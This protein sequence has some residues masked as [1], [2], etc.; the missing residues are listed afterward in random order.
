MF[1]NKVYFKGDECMLKETADIIPVFFACD[2]KYVPYV[3][4]AIT[5]ICENTFHP[6]SIC[7]IDGGITDHS[8]KMLTGLAAKREKVSLRI[9]SVDMRI[10]EGMKVNQLSL[11][12]Y[13]RF[14]IPW[15]VPELEKAIYLDSD[16][17]VLGD[18]SDLYRQNLHGKLLAA[19]PD[20]GREPREKLT[21]VNPNY[22]SFGEEHIYFNAGVLV[23]DCKKWREQ[24]VLKELLKI[25]EKYR[26]DMI[27]MDQ[28]VLNKY[29][30]CNYTTLSIE[31]NFMPHMKELC[32]S[33]KIEN[34]TPKMV[35]EAENHCRIIHFAGPVKPWES[36][37]CFNNGE[38]EKFW[39]YT[40]KTPF[41]PGLAA[42]FVEKNIISHINRCV[43]DIR[44]SL[45]EQTAK[46]SGKKK[47]RFLGFLPF[48]SIKYQSNSS[49]K[50]KKLVKV[51]GIPLYSKVQNSGSVCYKLLG[52]F[53]VLKI[54]HK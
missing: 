37:W 3:A 54:N 25:E 4:T 32:K 9:L 20:M 53:P 39:Y 10:F 35:D 46:V 50:I 36:K 14:L 6:L 22:V 21:G 16:I 42:N 49:N 51:F 45:S 52:I 1:K 38:F 23:I 29:F 12:S 2:E 8:K 11:S 15:I 30:D 5:S 27:F 18:I 28:D 34:I 40:A 31:Y 33:G 19:C 47:Y 26:N 17:M 41:G 44:W 7:I 48:A 24:N 43:N 13:C